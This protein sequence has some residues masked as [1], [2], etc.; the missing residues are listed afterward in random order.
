M[1]I[2]VINDMVFNQNS[3]LIDL[4]KGL[5]IIDP[6]YNYKGI[7]E[8]IE[9][10][11]V[12]GILLT[13]FH[14][15]H[16]A[17]V[18]KLIEEL[19]IDAYIHE[20]DLQKLKSDTLSTLFGFAPVPV[21][22]ERIKTFTNISPIKEI[23]LIHLPGHS[24]GSTCFKIGDNIFT[25]DVVFRD[26]IGRTDVPGA[27]PEKQKNNIDI[28]KKWNEEILLYPGHGKSVKVKELRE[29]NPFFK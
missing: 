24:E 29:V 8:E 12:W 27:T 11:K 10:K 19:N 5:V 7:K 25:G 23:E 22:S 18:D 26:S 21:I 1:N 28:I 3:Y 4:P 9:N 17:S 20:N 6:G 2:K 15:D 14:F 13:H 16:V